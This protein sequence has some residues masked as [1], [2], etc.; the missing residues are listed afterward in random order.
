[1]VGQRPRLKATKDMTVPELKAECDALKAAKARLV[2]LKEDMTE[3]NRVKRMRHQH[4]SIG[5]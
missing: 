4:R 5:G 1:M 3:K 2:K